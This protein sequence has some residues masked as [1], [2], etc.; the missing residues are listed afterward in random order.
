MT[1]AFIG[2]IGSLELLIIFI[3]A[4]LWI[5]ALIDVLRSEFRD[6][7]TKVVWLIAIIFVPFLGAIL[8]FSIGRRQKVA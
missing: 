6:G 8:Y 5:W 4:I 3:P 1:L 7:S 2:G